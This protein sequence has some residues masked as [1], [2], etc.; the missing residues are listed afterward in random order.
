MKCPKCCYEFEKQKYFPDGQESPKEGD[1]TVCF[2]CLAILKLTRNKLK[3]VTIGEWVE[4][5]LANRK[6]VIQIQR[7]IIS[8]GGGQLKKKKPVLKIEITV[9]S[10]DAVRFSY[11]LDKWK[12][13]GFSENEVFEVL[14]DCFER[15]ERSQKD[16]QEEGKGD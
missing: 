1:I 13:S 6:E 5:P 15:F 2:N 10:D 12:E 16:Y 3:P 8:E 11:I 14:L 9:N 4:L 7:D